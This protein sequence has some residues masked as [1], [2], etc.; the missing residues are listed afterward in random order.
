MGATLKDGVVYCSYE[1]NTTPK[2]TKCFEIQLDEVNGLYI[3][4][5]QA[6]T[7]SKHNLDLR[8]T[9]KEFLV[10]L[11]KYYPEYFI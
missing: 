6:M 4:K 10:I 7:K 8:K 2:T 1:L 3:K 11:E 9:A 5:V